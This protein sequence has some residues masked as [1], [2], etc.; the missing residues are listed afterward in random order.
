MIVVTDTPNNVE[1]R[2]IH[3][4]ASRLIKI[5]ISND[6]I[7]HA[8][9][10]LRNVTAKGIGIELPRALQEGEKV[11]IQIRNLEPISSTVAWSKDHRSGLLFDEPIDPS[12][13]TVKKSGQSQ[14]E[15]IYN[16]ANSY[17]VFNRFNPMSGIKRP[18]L[19]ARK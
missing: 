19:K 12:L 7:E 17:H 6:R 3:D 8:D 16:G 5:Q 11:S 14:V 10:I 1:K 9:A 2:S 15:G 18:A 13:L 4:R